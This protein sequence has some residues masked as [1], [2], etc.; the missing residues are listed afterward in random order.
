MGS[1]TTQ[2]NKP[3]TYEILELP[4]SV[5]KVE[6]VQTKS[7]TK[8]EEGVFTLWLEDHTVANLIREQL[9]SDKGVWF[10]GYQVPH[11]L[12]H[13]VEIRIQTSQ[14]SYTPEKAFNNALS[15]LGLELDKMIT[16]FKISVQEHRHSVPD[17]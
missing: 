11:P 16:T 10:A 17:L 4:D 13:K 14:H 6:Y 9:L 12:E 2:V 8:N 5:Q 15:A 1:R 7:S 3:D